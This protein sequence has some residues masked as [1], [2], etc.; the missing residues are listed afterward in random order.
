MKMRS[1][2]MLGLAA[3][4]LIAMAAIGAG[5]A[6]ATVLCG[7][8]PEGEVCPE[9]GAYPEGTTLP[10]HAENVTFKELYYGADVKCGSS[11]MTLSTTSQGG[12]GQAVTGAVEALGFEGCE[13]LGTP[14]HPCEI[15]GTELPYAASFTH[16][17]HTNGNGTLTIKSGGSGEPGFKIVCMGESCR[18]GLGAK[19]ELP[20]LGG[21]PASLLVNQVSLKWI[22]GCSTSVR[23]SATY[24]FTEPSAVYVASS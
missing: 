8:A 3:I 7:T 21:N 10:A 9:G 16:L 4:A 15:E 1:I 22:A 11:D 19:K 14:P 6:S 2:K 20:V 17:A 23:W 13:T 24:K 5:S 18:F 12:E